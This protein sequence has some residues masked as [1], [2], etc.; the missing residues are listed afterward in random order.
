ML[1]GTIVSL[2]AIVLLG[3]LL[4]YRKEMLA[5]IFKSNM[6]VA[7]NQFTENLEQT[8]DII[9][10]RLEEEATQL[11]LLLEEAEIK[12]GMLSQQVEH[13]NKIIEQMVELENNQKLV[14]I[15]QPEIKFVSNRE[16]NNTESLT[17]CEGEAW[18]EEPCINAGLPL[19]KMEGVTKETINNEKYRH[20][21]MMAEQG[22][23]ITEIAKVT[24]M[25]KGEILLLLQL[26]K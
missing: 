20:I 24:G 15:E 1:T 11:E 3:F 23:T 5:K 21:I 14:K 19:G 18:P 16:H 10:K 25:G 2:L 7:A 17:G 8:A 26:N 13:A 9:I 22:Y 4:I 12:I 6:S